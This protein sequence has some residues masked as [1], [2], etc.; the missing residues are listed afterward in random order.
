MQ[1]VAAA[2]G[3]CPPGQVISQLLGL[4]ADATFGSAL[5]F[6]GAAGEAEIVARVF[7][8]GEKTFAAPLLFLALDV[9]PLIGGIDGVGHRFA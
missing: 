9:L 5:L 4:S 2:F 6:F 8:A 3:M 1:Y 7:F